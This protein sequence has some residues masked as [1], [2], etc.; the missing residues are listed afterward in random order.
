MKRSELTELIEGRIIAAREGKMLI[1]R[2]YQSDSGIEYKNEYLFFI[3]PEITVCA[4]SLGFKSV[5][6]LMFD[7]LEIFGLYISGMNVESSEYL[8][9]YD[10]IAGHYGGI[11]ALSRNAEKNLSPQAWQKLHE[12]SGEKTEIGETYFA[13]NK[14]VK[15]R[16]LGSLEFLQIFREFDADSLDA[17][18]RQHSTIKLAPGTYC[19][20]VR[21]GS[22]KIYLINGFHPAQLNHFEAKG[23]V[24]V[25]ADIQSNVNWSVARNDFIG[26]TN[27]ADAKPGSLR[28]DLLVLMGKYLT[29]DIDSSHNGFH[30]SAGPVEA[31]AEQ[32]RYNS[33]FSKDKMKS[34][35]DYTFGRNLIKSFGTKAT[36]QLLENPVV[37]YNNEHVSVFDLTE[38]K[39]SFDVI[40][41][42][43]ITDINRYK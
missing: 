29:E 3:K 5:M 34:A 16:I 10:I 40:E 33:D 41:I 31:L 11:N 27:P 28:N 17:L 39:N 20:E 14:S 19:A 23:R 8:K 37:K 22:E 35:A 1:D 30:L 2:F 4:G 43:K 36:M 24:I 18:W 15:P 6:E 38:E 7:K 25:T 42:L 32:I 12:V 13:D 21:A 26:K 9:K